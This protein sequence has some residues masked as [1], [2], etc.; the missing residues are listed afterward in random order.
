MADKRSGAVTDMNI[1]LIDTLHSIHSH[2]GSKAPIEIICG[3]RSPKTNYKLTHS[4]KGVAKHSYHTL[5]KAADIRIEGMSLANMREIAESLNAGG[6]GYY[7][8]SGFLHV[9][10]GPTRTWRG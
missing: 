1:H 9:D 7:P 2:S 3:Y 4:K 5:G 10:V 8:R 6:V